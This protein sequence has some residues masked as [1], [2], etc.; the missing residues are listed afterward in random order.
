MD[1]AR[2]AK[3]VAELQI[4]WDSGTAYD[5]FTS[6]FVIYQPEDF[7]LRASWAAGVRSRLSEEA[8][9]F[10]ADAV[11]FVGV[12][13]HWIRSLPAPKDSR[14]ALQELERL[15]PAAITEAI[16]LM[17]CPD[18]PRSAPVFRRVF[19]A[20]SWTRA[21][22]EAL[23]VDPEKGQSR[24][25]KEECERLERWLDWISRPEDFGGMYL[26]G[27]TEFRESFFREEERR[28]APYIEQRLR[29]AQERSKTLE[30]TEL[31]EELTQG[32]RGGHHLDLPRLLMVPCYWCSPRIIYGNLDP[33]RR[34]ILFGARP[35]DASLIPEDEVP[36]SLYLALTALADTTRL[37][38]IRLLR[39]EPLT[40]AQL[41]RRLR[42][43][44]ST[45]S[46]HL[47]TLR[48]AGLIT[49][50]EGEGAELRYAARVSAI[51]EACSAMA[52]FFKL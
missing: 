40:Q 29:E 3:A 48:I 51:K 18:D 10:L 38:A 31:L 34:F 27:M 42:L 9:R 22:L 39:D 5:F 52:S 35:A 43:R 11:H 30:P 37:N 23:C 26:R 13:G 20:R 28:I 33:G 16:V 49:Y 17:E 24:R 50:L 25:S 47:K 14:A 19:D 8:R 7:G 45:M 1:S 41:A 15:G 36:G 12:P 4:E 44:P 2:A 32:L 46:H 21:D 6:L